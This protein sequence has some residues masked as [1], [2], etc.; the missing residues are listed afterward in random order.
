MGARGWAHSIARPWVPINSPLTLMVYRSV[1]QFW[2][3]LPYKALHESGQSG[4]GMS[5]VAFRL[6][7]QI[8]MLFIDIR[9]QFRLNLFGLRFELRSVYNWRWPTSN[10]LYLTRVNLYNNMNHC[11]W[12]AAVR[13]RT[14]LL[15]VKLTYNTVFY[16]VPK[17]HNFVQILSSHK[18]LMSTKLPSID[19]NH[20]P[21]DY[22][23]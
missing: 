13:R 20:T 7:Q 18:P 1:V 11:H 12:I 6:A 9:L 10:R 5:V 2:V 22:K 14:R 21:T 23:G 3:M 8:G 16:I 17:K 19:A 15:F 4:F